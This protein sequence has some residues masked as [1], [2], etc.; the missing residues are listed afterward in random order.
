VS[1]ARLVITAVVVEGR[2][3]SEV[4]RS[5]GVSK[6]WVSRLL[7]RYRIEG[8]A[9]FQPRSRRPSTSPK[10]TPTAVIDLVIRTRRQLTEAGLDAG[11]E[12]IAWH[13]RHHHQLSVSRATIHRILVR[14]G[15]VVPQPA[16][17]PKSSYLR[18]EAE[19]PNECWQSDFTHYRLSRPDGSPAAEVEII[20]WLDDHSRYALHVTAHPRIS[21]PIV[22]ASFRLAASQHGFPASTLTDNGMVYTARFAGGRGGRTALESE[23]R[24]FNIIQKNS[25][26]NHPTTCGKIER[27]QQTMKKWLRAQPSQPATI[28]DLQTLLDSFVA[29]YNQRRPHR[30][31]PRQAT[32]ATAY[33]TRPKATPAADRT[34]DHHNRVRQDRVDDTGVVTL[35]INGKLHHIGIGRTHARTPILMLINGLDIHI[36]HATT[37]QIIREL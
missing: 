32:P 19:L 24:Q 27:F 11:A 33:Q 30:S 8:E 13:L 18:F 37:G 10:A 20:S 15:L 25:R 22:L 23:L 35:R 21:G 29:E 31:L 34:R 6:G 14:H 9:A 17:R 3:Q 1:K 28:T 26:P 36:I 2:T 7:A 5:Y 4:A 12:T 16:K